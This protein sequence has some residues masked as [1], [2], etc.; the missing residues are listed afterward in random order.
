[1]ITVAAAGNANMNAWLFSPASAEKAI[2]VGAINS[3]WNIA[4]FSNWGNVVEVFAPG[5]GVK[6]AWNIDDASTKVLDGTS[7]ATPHVVGLV[8]YAFS[9][10]QI[11][12]ANIPTWITQ[13]A[14]ASKVTG[15]LRGAANLIAN[16][17]NALQVL[18]KAPATA[19][20]GV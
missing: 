17:G 18:L 5:V 11:A 7:M 4:Q 20:G 13:T 19:K 3:N 15:N 16:N 12:P 2:T 10:N 14:T 8:L 1:V 9:V 6:S